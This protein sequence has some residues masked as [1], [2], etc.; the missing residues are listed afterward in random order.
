M[1]P[2][3]L[4]VSSISEDRLLRDGEGGGPSHIILSAHW[5]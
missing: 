1:K 5:S 2:V 4:V 3:E